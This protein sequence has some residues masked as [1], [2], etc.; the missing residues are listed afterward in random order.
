MPFDRAGCCAGCG[1]LPF[2]F[3]RATAALAY[4]GALSQAL[5]RWKHGGHRHIAKSL[6]HYVAP[7]LA[8]AERQG[9]EVACPVPLHPR[10]LR[11]RGFNQALDLLHAARDRRASI[12]IGCDA[13]VRTVDTPSLGKGSPRERRRIV[14]NVFVVARPKQVRGRRVLVVDDVMTTGATLAEC[15]RVLLEAGAKEVAVI[16][17]ARAV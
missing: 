7:L 12:E 6:S 14:A 5:L 13:L 11:A 3:A 1:K 8:Q 10:R 16:T 17:L 9:A 15:A 2:A 4:G